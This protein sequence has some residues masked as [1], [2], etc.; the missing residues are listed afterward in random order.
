MALEMAEVIAT[1]DIQGRLRELHREEAKQ[2]LTGTSSKNTS[3]IT[4][5]KM[6]QAKKL[7]FRCIGPYRS[8][9]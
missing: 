9:D 2:R 8:V 5:G 4:E 3:S 6:T 7:G 1:A